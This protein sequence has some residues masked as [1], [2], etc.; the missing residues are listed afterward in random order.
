MSWMKDRTRSF[1]QGGLGAAIL[2]CAQQNLKKVK[3]G[4]GKTSNKLLPVLQIPLGLWS[5][6]QAIFRK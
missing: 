1:A 5:L 3:N 2:R 4:E 6:Y